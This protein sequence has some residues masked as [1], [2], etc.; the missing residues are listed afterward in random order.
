[1]HDDPVHPSDPAHE[2]SESREPEPAPAP[3]DDAHAHPQNVP[4][5]FDPAAGAQLTEHPGPLSTAEGT[6]V[7]C[8]ACHALRDWLLIAYAG[9]TWIR[10]RCAHEWAPGPLAANDGEPEPPDR[11]WAT[12]D[13]A[14]VSMG[15]DGLFAGAY[16]N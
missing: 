6:L 1:M 8:P 13:H 12:L 5:E 14:I 2:P 15:F 7:V 9:D 11:Y 3:R 4:E 10:C 16:F